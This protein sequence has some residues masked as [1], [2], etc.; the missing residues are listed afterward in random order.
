MRDTLVGNFSIDHLTIKSKEQPAGLGFIMANSSRSTLARRASLMRPRRTALSTITEDAWEMQRSGLDGEGTYGLPL[1]SNTSLS[2]LA[3]SL[4][5]CPPDGFAELYDTTESE[6]ESDDDMSSPR[7][8]SASLTASITQSSISSVGSRRHY[9]SLQIPTTAPQHASVSK[10]SPLPPTPPPKIPV[11]PAALSILGSLVP[12]LNAPPSLDGSMSSDQMSNLTAPSTPDMHAAPDISLPPLDENIDGDSP[13]PRGD[14]RAL[15][16]S[17]P[18]A[19]SSNDAQPTI[20]SSERAEPLQDLTPSERPLLYLPKNALEMLDHICLDITPEP[21]TGTSKENVEMWQIERPPGHPGTSDIG[22]PLSEYSTPSLTNLSIPSP[23]VFFASLEPRAR[24]AWSFPTEKDHPSTADAERFYDLPWDRSNGDIVEQVIDCPERPNADQQLTAIYRPDEP[25]TAFRMP[26]MFDPQPAGVVK[27]AQAATTDDTVVDSVEWDAMS[28]EYDEN[29][30]SRLRYRALA[31]LDLTSQWLAQQ[32]L[33]CASPGEADPQA[34]DEEED[35]KADLLVGGSSQGFPESVSKQSIHAGNTLDTLPGP[36]S[37]LPDIKHRHSIYLRGLQF[38]CDHSSNL[39]PFLH[40]ATRYDAIQSVRSALVDTHINSLLGRYELIQHERPPYR[41]PF[42]KSPRQNTNKSVVA[43]RHKFSNLLKEQLVLAQLQEAVWAVDALK[44]LQRGSLITSPV[45]RLLER[46]VVPGKTSK[47]PQ[48]PIRVLDLCGHG[49]CEWGWRLALEYP[50]IDVY[51][52]STKPQAV[53]N[54][55]RG[56]PNHRHICI[57]HPWKL[58]FSDNK[59]DLISTRSLHSA[60][61]TTHPAGEVADEYDLCLR[62]CRRCLKPGRYLEFLIMDANI[63]RS[64]LSASAVSTKFA[65]EL[66]E[67]GYDAAPT[68]NFLSRLYKARFIGIK[69]AWIFLPM[70]TEHSAPEPRRDGPQHISSDD[71]SQFEAV[72]PPVGS[73]ADVASVTG[74]L[75]GWMWEQWLLKVQMEMGRERAKLLEGMGSFFYEG[76][77]NGAGWTCLSGWAMKP[78]RKRR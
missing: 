39:D 23:G 59:F 66:E 72:Q 9:P 47:R 43:D 20:P 50:N 36:P 64:G 19:P 15:L 75:G 35:A 57:L 38:L 52:V 54:A 11:S 37:S 2:R 67:C 42:S 31:T 40:R 77:R 63:C 33:H 30:E 65:S 18:P 56:P 28:C 46:A 26:P 62:E 14:W 53:N 60:L 45:S 41:G 44:Y 13:N 34:E 61:K 70:G 49:S 1:P 74:L 32:V 22:S 69:R 51:T 48:R 17:F 24:R 76:R 58:P 8:R 4:S 6:G 10:A 27:G 3:S 21:L 16:E 29:Y 12:A 55:I 7:T 5:Q 71:M 78:Q 73:T 68:R 25:Q